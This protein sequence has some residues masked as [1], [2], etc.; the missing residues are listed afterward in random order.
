VNVVRQQVSRRGVLGG[1]ER[2]D[3]ERERHRAPRTFQREG[4]Q[5][6]PDEQGGGEF[7]DDREA[8]DDRECDELVCPH[9]A[10]RPLH[11]VS[12]DTPRRS[13]RERSA[14]ARPVDVLLIEF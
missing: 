14:R 6:W 12:D 7:V 13:A 8:D 5:H 2:A 9:P 4:E 3:G 10:A 11:P 1:E